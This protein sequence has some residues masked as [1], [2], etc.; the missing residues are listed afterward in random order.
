MADRSDSVRLRPVERDF[1]RF[2]IAVPCRL[3]EALGLTWDQ[4][5]DDLT[6]WTQAGTETK[7][8]QEHAFAIHPLAQ[9]VL[10]NRRE[11]NPRGLVFPAKSGGMIT[12]RSHLNDRARATAPDVQV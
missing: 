6:T 11:E 12:G 10:R 9:E 3:G 8:G 5:D 7:N 2:M 1:V 4:L